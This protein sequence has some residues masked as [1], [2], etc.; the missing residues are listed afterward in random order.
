MFLL[1]MSLEISNII[2][3]YFSDIYF[4]IS[5][6]GG[7]GGGIHFLADCLGGIMK[8]CMDL[9]GDI[10]KRAAEKKPSAPSPPPPCSIHNECSLMIT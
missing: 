1:N 8:I 10:K 9:G 2:V 3:Y 7:G 6:E 4:D 5:C